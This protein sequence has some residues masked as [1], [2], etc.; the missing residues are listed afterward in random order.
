MKMIRTL[1]LLAAVS[2][3]GT[4]CSLMAPQYTGSIDNVQK[5]K[6]S[7][8]QAMKVGTF[9]SIPGK[10]NANPISLRGSSMSSP[11]EAS[12]AKYLAEALKIELSLANKHAATSDYELSGELV[13]NDL[14]AS[15]MSIGTGDIQARF[16]VKKGPEVR[17]DQ[18]K[19]VHHE[20]ES[21]FVGATAIPRAT[22]EYS[23][24]VQKLLAA[25]YADPLFQQ[26]TK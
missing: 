8:V 4:G 19:T 23:N 16:M 2:V 25:L 26:S 13:K 14:D 17:Y 3:L 9:A 11:Y 7:D 18:V 5:L 20:W 1:F 6:S 22:Q 15:G 24:L 10:E 21:S 12:Y